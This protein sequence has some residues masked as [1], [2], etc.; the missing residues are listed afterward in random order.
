MSAIYVC[1]WMLLIIIEMLSADD[2]TYKKVQ[3]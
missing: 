3:Y 1:A 2:V